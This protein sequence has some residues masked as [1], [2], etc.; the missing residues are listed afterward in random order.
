MAARRK[1]TPNDPEAGPGFEEA[2]A[3]L[4]AVVEAMEEEQLPLED[5]VAHY[6][7][8][9]ALLKRCETVLKS[10]RERLELITLRNQAENALDSAAA[11][12][13]G[14]APPPETPEDDPDDDDDIRLF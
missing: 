3:E 11:T 14:G 6:E 10:A 8:G 7:K 13:H 5:L 9:S 12:T 4:E 2:L 1:T